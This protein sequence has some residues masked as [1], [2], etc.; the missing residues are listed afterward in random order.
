MI[1]KQVNSP[2]PSNTPTEFLQKDWHFKIKAKFIPTIMT[3]I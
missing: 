1:L 2:I 3:M